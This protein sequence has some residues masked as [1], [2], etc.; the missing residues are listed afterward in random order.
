MIW[1]ISGQLIFN[2]TVKCYTKQNLELASAKVGILAQ[3]MVC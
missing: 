2:P 3:K 1:F